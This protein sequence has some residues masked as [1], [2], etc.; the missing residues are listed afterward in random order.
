MCADLDKSRLCNAKRQESGTRLS[1]P[2]HRRRHANP[3][4]GADA[5]RELARC[6]HE[7]GFPAW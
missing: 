6:K 2:L 3:L 7:F 5:F 4:G 1:R